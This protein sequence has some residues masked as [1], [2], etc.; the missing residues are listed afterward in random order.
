MIISKIPNMINTLKF[1]KR[2]LFP[3]P[4]VC[5][6]YSITKLWQWSERSWGQQVQKWCDLY[7]VFTVILG[8]GSDGQMQ[9]CI[10]ILGDLQ[11]RQSMT[12]YKRFGI[13]QRTELF[14]FNCHSL[15]NTPLRYSE[16]ALLVFWTTYSTQISRGFQ[17]PISHG[18][19]SVL[20]AC[21]R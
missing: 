2:C 17:V 7:A 14:L 6:V 20:S 9:I 12:D 18:F 8:I 3:E 5:T 4:S 15:S 21:G 1:T 16:R 11:F 19:Q 10:N 13:M